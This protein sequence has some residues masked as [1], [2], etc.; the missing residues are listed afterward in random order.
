MA[1]VRT[2]GSSLLVKTI[3]RVA[4]AIRPSRVCTSSPFMS[5]IKIS[6]T[7]TGGWCRCACCR[8]ACGSVNVFAFQ[9]AACSSLSVDF[10]TEGSSSRRQTVAAAVRKPFPADGICSGADP[11]SAGESCRLYSDGIRF[12]K[13]ATLPPRASCTPFPARTRRETIVSA[14]H[15]LISSGK[16]FA[17]AGRTCFSGIQADRRDSTL[18]SWSSCRCAAGRGVVKA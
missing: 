5:G 14:H 15:R 9:P 18:S 6:I 10:S 11:P 13:S 8:K 4:G 12:I 1:L 17:K 16:R 2:T 7:A 3:T